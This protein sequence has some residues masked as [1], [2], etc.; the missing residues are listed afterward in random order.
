[1]VQLSVCIEMFWRDLP[2]EERIARVARLGFPAFEFWSWSNKDLPRIKATMEEYQ[3]PI[4][5]MTFEPGSSLIKRGATA[6]LV[7]G[8]RDTAV[9]ARAL[10]CQTVIATAGNTLDDETDEMSRRRVVRLVPSCDASA[11]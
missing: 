3:I 5:A 2:V 6:T 7:Q 11:L 10:S 9:A 8:M 4:A 1:M